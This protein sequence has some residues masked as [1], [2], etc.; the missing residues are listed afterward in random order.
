MPSIT[1]DAAFALKATDVLR[2]HPF[3]RW[4]FGDSIGFEGL[5]ASDRLTGTRHG[6]DFVHGFL[7]GWAADPQPWQA[8]DFTAPGRILVDIALE[9]DD[10]I[11]RDVAV[12]LARHLDARR[13]VRGATITFEDSGWC[14]RAPYSGTVLSPDDQALMQD[15]GPGVWLDCM[16]FDA[17]FFAAM[18]R[19]DQHSGWA[20]KAVAE[21]LAYR[22]LLLDPGT[23]LYCHF[24]LERP[25]HAFVRGWGRGQGWALLGLIDV[26]ASCPADT[27]RY[28][29]I[30]SEIERLSHAMLR[31]QQPDGHWWCLAHDPRSGPETSTAA[32]MATAFFRALRL[33][34]LPRSNFE[35]PAQHALDA[36]RR[37]MDDTGV[38]R[39]VS[40]AVY[41]ALIE[42]HYWHVP[43]DL[44]VPWGQGPALTAMAEA[45]PWW[46][47][48]NANSSP[49]AQ[50]RSASG[51]TELTQ[52][53]ESGGA[54]GLENG[55]AGEGALR[56]EPVVD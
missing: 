53:G 49:F 7:R 23:G 55:S 38:L 11:L 32:F 52:P 3:R 33:G 1:T 41:A 12:A 18:H 54:V 47:Q 20:E 16:H 56:V 25:A 9:E 35:G 27:P 10:A 28:D 19:L 39:G 2:A 40:A 45:A 34:L 6:R 17:P 43:L 46:C 37:E 5:L 51:Y 42:D 44:V 15:P 30:K 26:A 29:E 48:T 24:W 22:D 50:T 8:L 21:L 14:L 36:V 13:R 4:F 31:W